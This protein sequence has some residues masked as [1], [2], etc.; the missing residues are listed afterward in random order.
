[1]SQLVPVPLLSQQRGVPL[2]IEQVGALFG[3]A[4]AI[5]FEQPVQE[6]DP[7]SPPKQKQPLELLDEITPEE[8]DDELL[9]VAQLI[10]VAFSLLKSV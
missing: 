9:D 6:T 5:V 2:S 4:Q 1:M 7:P 8:L 10:N 3:S